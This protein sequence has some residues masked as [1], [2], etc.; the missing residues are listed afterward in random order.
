MVRLLR[1]ARMTRLLR[2]LPE[3]VTLIKG[4]IVAT[5]AVG[6]CMLLLVLLIYVFAIVM[7]MFA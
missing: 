1:L 5:R 6:C 2:A 7:H 3:L 4:M